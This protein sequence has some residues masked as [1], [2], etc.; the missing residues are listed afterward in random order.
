MLLLLLQFLFVFLAQHS[1]GEARGLLAGLLQ[2]GLRLGRACL[3]A[4][5]GRAGAGAATSLSAGLRCLDVPPI[6]SSMILD[7]DDVRVRGREARVHL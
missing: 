3:A 6:L 1:E 5:V 2:G 7:V 4:C